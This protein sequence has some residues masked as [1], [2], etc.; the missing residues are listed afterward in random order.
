MRRRPEENGRN[1]RARHDRPH[2]GRARFAAADVDEEDA[3][4]RA[5]DGDAAEDKRINDRRR[6]SSPSVKRADQDRADQADRVG[7]ENVRRHAGAIADIIAHVVRDRGRI[8][9]IV[10]LEVAFDFADQIGADV[11]RL[12]VN[13]AAESREDADQARAQRQADQALHRRSWPII[14]PA[15]V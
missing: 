5:E 1:E 13:A 6:R 3:A 9:R 2:Q 8:A 4:D 12:G 15:T 7:L 10:F 11:R 14:L